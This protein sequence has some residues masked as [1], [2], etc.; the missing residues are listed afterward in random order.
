MF[1]RISYKPNSFPDGYPD[2]LYGDGDGTVNRRSLEGCLMWDGKQKQ[3][4][5]HQT[6]SNLDHM[7]ILHDK[8]ILNYIQELVG[9]I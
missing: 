3:K 4:I 6:F 9:N 8:R 7:N 1:F 5:Y 2:F